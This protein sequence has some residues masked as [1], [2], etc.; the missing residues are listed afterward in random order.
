[1][2][3][4]IKFVTTSFS[5]FSAF[6]NYRDINFLVA[7][8]IFTFSISTLSRQSFLCRDILSVVL[9]HLCRDIISS[10]ILIAN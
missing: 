6:E 2:C 8:N 9:Q 10:P 1:M 7:T 3:R 5:Y 4:D